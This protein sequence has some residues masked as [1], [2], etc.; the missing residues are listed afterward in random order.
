MND[1]LCLL[2]MLLTNR[3][4]EIWEP[5]RRKEYSRRFG[6]STRAMY[7][8]GQKS[9]IRISHE[10]RGARLRSP[11]FDCLEQRVE[12]EVFMEAGLR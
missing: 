6:H 8:Q 5:A 9:P 10:K 2:S 3:T 7:G 1:L 4:T 11:T 12:T